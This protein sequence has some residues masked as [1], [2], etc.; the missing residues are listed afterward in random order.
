MFPPSNAWVTPGFL[1]ESKLSDVGGPFIHSIQASYVPFAGMKRISF[2]IHPGY[3]IKKIY[4][5][6]PNPRQDEYKH[7]D[8]LATK[9]EG[10]SVAFSEP[11]T[12]LK[13]LICSYFGLYSPIIQVSPIG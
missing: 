11:P 9:Q 3:G 10:Y 12:T 1:P 8:I 4:T 5:N 2:D 7:T 6:D 13:F